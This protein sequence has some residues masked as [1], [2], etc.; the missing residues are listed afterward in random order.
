MAT[1]LVPPGSSIRSAAAAAVEAEP[2]L[3]ENRLLKFLRTMSA[4]EEQLL[5]HL[6]ELDHREHEAGTEPQRADE[7][8]ARP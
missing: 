4:E 1:P 8:S 7:P 5:E 3:A 6:A 2:E